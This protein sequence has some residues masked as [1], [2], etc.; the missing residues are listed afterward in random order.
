MPSDR[1]VQLVLHQRLRLLQRRRLGLLKQLALATPDRPIDQRQTG[2]QTAAWANYAAHPSLASRRMR[3]H[4]SRGKSAFNW[5]LNIV[6]V[7]CA[8]V[9]IWQFVDRFRSRN[10]EA[11][12]TVSVGSRVQL[13]GVNWA[14][15]PKTVV[16]ALS[17]YC[18][19]CR[20]SAP[21][22]RSLT[23][24]SSNGRFRTLAV[25]RESSKETT[26]LLPSLGIDRIREIR[27]GDLETLGIRATPTLLIVDGKGAVQSAWTGKLNLSQEKEVF[28][29]LAVHDAPR[30]P[31]A[32]T[33]APAALQTVAPS[34]L[35]VLLSDPRTVLLDSRDRAL[36]EQAHIAGA[37]NIPLDEILSRAP[38]E[39]PKEETIYVYCHFAKTCQDGKKTEDK[40]RMTL[41][42]ISSGVLGW[43]AFHKVRYIPDD[44]SALSAQKVPV[45]GAL[46]K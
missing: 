18:Q 8:L 33:A 39:M 24:A 40:S 3:N 21:F 13:P 37:V 7:A 41:C 2:G 43:A 9:V 27:H 42:E 1:G 23:D 32:A 30:P 19:H 6:S 17:A 16:L 46:C 26:S 38:H 45:A 34:E 11:M 44:L 29:K 5:A 31:M 25:L 22:Y 36:F 10:G 28:A 35:R 15:S 20:T 14:D 4:M 12:N